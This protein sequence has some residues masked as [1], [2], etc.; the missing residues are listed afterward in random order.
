MHIN[1][2]AVQI[3]Q[4]ILVGTSEILAYATALEFFY[5]EAPTSMRSVSQVIYA[6]TFVWIALHPS[7]LVRNAGYR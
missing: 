3:P 1:T 7:M 6:Y 5:S 4:F 2:Y